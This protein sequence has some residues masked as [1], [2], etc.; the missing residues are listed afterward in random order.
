MSLCTFLPVVDENEVVGLN[1][2]IRMI[3]K[4]LIE[5]ALQQSQGVQIRAAE[6]LGIQVRS[7]WHRVKKL[8]ID[9]SRY[10]Q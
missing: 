10:K 1:E 4:T 9:V 5:D 3:E 2:R 7:L 6:L 8:D